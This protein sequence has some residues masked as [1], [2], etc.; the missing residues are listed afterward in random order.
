MKFSNFYHYRKTYLS[1]T[2]AISMACAPATLLAA[3]YSMADLEFLTVEKN[4]D[5]FFQ[6]YLDIRPSER[7]ERWKELVQTMSIE[8]INRLMREKNYARTTLREINKRSDLYPFRDDEH[9]LFKK[10]Q[11]LNQYFDQ[12]FQKKE[13]NCT[14]DL[15]HSLS[16]AIKDSEWAYQFIKKHQK[17][18]APEELYKLFSIIYKSSDAMVFCQ[19]TDLSQWVIKK[20]SED[21]ARNIKKAESLES[22]ISKS[23]SVKMYEATKE[24]LFE[25]R[26]LYR[27]DLYEYFKSYKLIQKS[28]EELFYIIFTLDSPEIGDTLNLAWSFI[29]TLAEDYPKRML[30]LERL[31]KLKTLPGET[32]FQGPGYDRHLAIIKLFKTNFPEYLDLYAENC[33]KSLN[34]ANTGQPIVKSCHEFLKIKDIDQK[35]RDQYQN[36]RKSVEGIKK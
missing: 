6:H 12:C 16:L 33:L 19:K 27:L 3:S 4:V 11:F 17:S 1:L 8:W 10:N 28:D 26:R 2:L 36:L 13:T 34:E 35:W 7:K 24:Q 18:L 22:Y 9:F 20:I 15:R 29:Q 21:K 30:L 23:C 25:G 14:E 5:E 32:V 31:K